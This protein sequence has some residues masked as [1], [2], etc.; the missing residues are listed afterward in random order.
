MVYVASAEG[1]R[2]ADPKGEFLSV[3]HASPVFE[4]LGKTGIS[5]EKQPA[6]HEPVGGTVRYHVREGA[7][8]V[9]GYDWEQYLKAIHD[10]AGE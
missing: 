4:L 2:W 8:D 10:V 1:D 9:T 5:S 6:N 7:H 3:M